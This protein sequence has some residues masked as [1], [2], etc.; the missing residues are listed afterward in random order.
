M[1]TPCWILFPYSL[2]DDMDQRKAD[3]LESQLLIE[4]LEQ[5]EQMLEAQN[6]ILQVE[7]ISA[8]VFFSHIISATI[9][10]HHTNSILLLDY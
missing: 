5:R 3:L 8:T 9:T 4:Q 2:F 1:L 10:P 6:G 7:I